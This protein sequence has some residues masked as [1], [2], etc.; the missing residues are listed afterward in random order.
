MCF[1]AAE[2]TLTHTC[3]D[4]VDA[5]FTGNAPSGFYKYKFPPVYDGSDYGVKVCN[6]LFLHVRILS[7]YWNHFPGT[8]KLF[9]LQDFT[10]S[11]VV[12][13]AL[14]VMQLVCTNLF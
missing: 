10:I 8:F 11:Q 7:I 13:S 1:Q 3:G 9:Q 2:R 14:Y 6:C 12:N 5:L 4:S